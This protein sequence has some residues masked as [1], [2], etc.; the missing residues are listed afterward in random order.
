MSGKGS[1]AD[2]RFN[3][4]KNHAAF[5]GTACSIRGGVAGVVAGGSCWRFFKGCIKTK[6]FSSLPAQQSAIA[7][8]TPKTQN[9]SV[10]H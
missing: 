9:T 8:D 6:P 2:E 1:N 5:V 10:P 7:T 3:R 4:L